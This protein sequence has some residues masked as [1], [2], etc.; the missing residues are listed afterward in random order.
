MVSALQ[1][2]VSSL[3]G[4]LH[5]RDRQLQQMVAQREAY[6]EQAKQLMALVEEMSARELAAQAS[7]GVDEMKAFAELDAR[8]SS[9]RNA[10]LETERQAVETDLQAA[11]SPPTP[12]T[13]PLQ[14]TGA[15][16]AQVADEP[17]DGEAADEAQSLLVSP[18]LTGKAG[19]ARPKSSRLLASEQALQEARGECEALRVECSELQAE[20]VSL[21]AQHASLKGELAAAL[22]ATTRSKG[23]EGARTAEIIGQRDAALCMGRK[24]LEA[25]T[26]AVLQEL[27]LCEADKEREAMSEAPLEELRARLAEAEKGRDAALYR[28]EQVE[29]E[30][31]AIKEAE[32][33][34]T[35]QLAAEMWGMREAHSVT[36]KELT[37]ELSC[38]RER[39]KAT[40]LRKASVG[41]REG[42]AACEQPQVLSEKA[43]LENTLV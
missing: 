19:R 18:P 38:E 20:C 40:R 27:A 12:P 26:E 42:R 30:A 34:H 1:K 43:A 21:R 28:A 3:Y 7:V 31:A 15:S 8:F 17:T 14:P 4:M 37:R 6:Q 5:T 10:V 41:G 33:K 25:T 35:R 16:P 23:E 2:S 22:V 11:K 32:E 39:H 24:E 9:V 13:P 36:V 29:R